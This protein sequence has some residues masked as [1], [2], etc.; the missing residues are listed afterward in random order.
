MLLLTTLLFSLGILALLFIFMGLGLI[1]K[2][3]PLQ[4]SCG[5]IKALGLGEECEVC[6]GDANKCERES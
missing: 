1:L 5:G 4:G 2:R 3:Q 6:G